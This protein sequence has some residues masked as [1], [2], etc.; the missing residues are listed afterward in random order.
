MVCLHPKS[1]ELGLATPVGGCWNSPWSLLGYKQSLSYVPAHTVFLFLFGVF[2]VPEIKHRTLH[3]PARCCTTE[4]Y[5]QPL[6]YYPLKKS[7][8]PMVVL[9]ISSHQPGR[10]KCALLCAVSLSW[11]RAAAATH[12]F[13]I[14]ASFYQELIDNSRRSVNTGCPFFESGTHFVPWS[15]RKV[16]NMDDKFTVMG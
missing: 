4:L 6:Q 11:H 13:G 7:R 14:Y 15:L 1:R 2:L 10:W 12:I 8:L 5:P 16:K 3:L 9:F